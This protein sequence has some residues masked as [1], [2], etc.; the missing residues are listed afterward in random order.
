[1]ASDSA[2]CV[3]NLLVFGFGGLRPFSDFASQLELEME[4]AA[5]FA[6]RILVARCGGF[7]FGNKRKGNV[8]QAKGKI[9]QAVG[10]LTRNDELKA[11]GQVR[12]RNAVETPSSRKAKL[13]RLALGGDEESERR[14]NHDRERDPSKEREG[15]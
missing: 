9:K 8:D 10:T 15:A 4:L 3:Q 5:D 11:E 12:L 14:H 13:Q 6:S 7:T 2:A 1:M